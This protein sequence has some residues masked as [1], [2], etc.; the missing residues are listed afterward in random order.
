MTSSAYEVKNNSCPCERPLKVKKNGASPPGTSFFVL[1]IFT[2]FYYANEEI[3]DVI[4]V[5]T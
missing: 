5:S 4:G 1:E 3:N 2:F